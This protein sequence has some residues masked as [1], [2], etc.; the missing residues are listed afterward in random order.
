MSLHQGSCGILK[1][2]L[3]GLC[4]RVVLLLLS[5]ARPLYLLQCLR[6]ENYQGFAGYTCQF[7]L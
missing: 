4:G 6:V 5:L 2:L 3:P 7:A 1:T